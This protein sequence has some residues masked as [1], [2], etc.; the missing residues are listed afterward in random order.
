MLRVAADGLARFFDRRVVVAEPVEQDGERI[1]RTVVARISAL[2]DVECLACLRLITRG[3]VVIL[4]GDKEPFT[5]ADV[6]AV[7][8]LPRQF[9]AASR[10]SE[11]AIE[12]DRFRVGEREPR[13]ERDGA[14]EKWN[15][16]R[17]APARAP[18]RPFCIGLQRVQRRRSRFFDRDVVPRRR[19][20]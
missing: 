19:R 15:R 14:L 10:F 7:V 12:V 13:V 20:S 3:A 18:G 8:R 4:V 5:L 6:T 17:F 9:F 11:T 16:L 2:P 1:R